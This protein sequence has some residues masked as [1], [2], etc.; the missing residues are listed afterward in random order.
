MTDPAESRNI[1]A[2]EHSGYY[3]TAGPDMQARAK[4]KKRLLV[5]M[6]LTGSMMVV[7]FIAGIL[8]NSLALVSDAGHMLTHF[9]ALSV[10]YLG[11]W[12]ATKEASPEKTFGFY[13]T[14]VLAA[15]FNGITLI[16]ITGYILYIAYG[17]ILSPKPILEVQM[18]IVATIGLLVNLVSA[19]ILWKVGKQ[20]LNVKGAYIHLLSD[21][22]SSVAI[23]IGAIIIHYSGWLVIDPILSVIISIVILLWAFGLL[24]D[25]VNILLESAPRHIKIEEIINAVKSSFPSIKS[26]HDVHVWEITTNMYALTCHIVTEDMKVSQSCQLR[27]KINKLLEEKFKIGHTNIEFDCL[28]KVASPEKPSADLPFQSH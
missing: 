10:S 23:I 20:D 2:I 18:L 14:E 11:A 15:L 3:H 26:V 25:S 17:R 12:F 9:F 1:A 16:L 5:T 19:A 6:S 27:D 7:E 4:R 28:M 24:K 22:F 21:T 8:T 13:R